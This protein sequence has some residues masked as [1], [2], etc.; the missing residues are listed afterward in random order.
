MRARNMASLAA[1]LALALPAIAAAPVPRASPD[2]T[3]IDSD[4]HAVALSSLKGHVVVLEFMLMRC[5]GCL[6]T[7]QTVNK[8]YGELATD[9]FRPIGVLFDNGMGGPAARSVAETLKI[10]YLV[11]YTTSDKVDSYLGRGMM[12]RL[13]VPQM[14]VIDRAGVIRAQGHPTG[15]EDLT[16]ETYLRN[17]IRAL[18]SE[19]AAA[20]TTEKMTYSPGTAR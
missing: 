13:Q 1:V 18:L 14:V 3:I 8:L 17:L 15:E 11:G 9:D 10:N 2:L 4:D 6:R 7:A 20:G 12:E 5:A 19:N 16:N